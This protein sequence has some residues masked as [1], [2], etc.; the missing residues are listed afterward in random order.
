MNTSPNSNK[1]KEKNLPWW[2]E[3][4]FVQIGL[5]DKF[6]IKILNIKKESDE[7]PKNEK[8]EYEAQGIK[9]GFKVG[10]GI[11]AVVSIFQYGQ[12]VVTPS[13]SPSLK[14]IKIKKVPKLEYDIPQMAPPQLKLTPDLMRLGIEYNDLREINEL[15]NRY[16][17]Y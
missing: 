12:S 8:K 4:L 6:L 13:P 9:L 15:M 7:I 5:P 17:N 11:I 1:K 14:D 10:M 2:V 16:P 3:L